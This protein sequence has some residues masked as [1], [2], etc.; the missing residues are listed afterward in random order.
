M[1]IKEIARMFNDKISGCEEDFFLWYKNQF[2][3]ILKIFCFIFDIHTV[4]RLLKCHFL[5]YS[6][7]QELSKK[8]TAF[9][10]NKNFQWNKLQKKNHIQSRNF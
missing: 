2:Y 4:Y 6:S 5:P 7:E 1:S 9:Q 10:S 3:A 8:K